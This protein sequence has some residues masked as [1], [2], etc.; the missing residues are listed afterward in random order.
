MTATSPNTPSSIPW[1]RRLEAQVL[2]SILLLVGAATTAILLAAG[3]VMKDYSLERSRKDMRLAR[4]SFEQLQRARTDFAGEQCQLIVELP[5]FRSLL[6]DARVLKEQDAATI[7]MMSESYRVKLRASFCLVTDSQGKWLGTPSGLEGPAARASL[8]P[9]VRNATSG[10][11]Y[12]GILMLAG[13]PYLVVSEPAQFAEELLGTLSTGYRLDDAAAKEL[14]RATGCE[15]TFVEGRRIC[16]T[17]LQ[18]SGAAPAPARALGTSLGGWEEVPRLGDVG[19]IPYVGSVA[20]LSLSPGEAS[21]CRL[22]LL[23]PWRPTQAKLAQIEW[24]LLGIGVCTFLVATAGGTLVSRRMSRP[25][26]ELATAARAIAGGAWHAR[27]P[28]GGAAEAAL[29]AAAF[30]DMTATLRH[31]YQEAQ[32]KSERLAE[33]VEELQT[34][35]S[36]T[37]QALCRALDT[38]DNETEGHSERVAYYALRI[39]QEMRLDAEACERLEWGGLLHDIGKIG[40]PD[41]ILRKPARLTDEEMA[42]MRRHC[43]WGVQIVRGVSHLEH[44]VD[45]IYSHHEWFD[46]SGYP[47]GLAGSG[48]PLIARIF[49][50]ADALDAITSDRPYRRARSFAEARV[51]IGRCSGTQFDPDV[52]AAFARVAEEL[53][54]WRK[55]LAGHRSG[56]AREREF[57]APGA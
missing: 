40:V 47:R 3:Q 46:G 51:E 37:M 25:L 15:V 20:P 14:A 52:V 16:A 27:A 2:L 30:N 56:I 39:A 23:Q 29:T 18:P 11:E 12:R 13:M 35:Y 38:R 41:S 22:L 54:A 28:E 36:T 43:E 50:L 6:T 8:E 24:L 55:G 7:R 19:G 34:A 17:S 53:E 4:V 42:V 45:V 57:L 32:T 31:Y 26:S 21:G 5:I 49:A 44:T 10:T 1:L 48:I 9:A 33:S